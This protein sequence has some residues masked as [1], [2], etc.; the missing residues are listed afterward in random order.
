[1][2][3]ARYIGLYLIKNNFCYVHGLG[4]LELK[5]QPATYDG[6]L[7]LPA[8]YRVDVTTGGSIDDN[9]ANF[10]ATN[11]Q[12]SIS[13]AANALR[14][15]SEQA[16]KDLEAGKDVLLPAVGKFVQENGRVVFITNDNFSY[17]P[18]GMPTIRNN[19]QIEEQV[20][21]QVPIPAAIPIPPPEPKKRVNWTMII[22]VIVLLV[23]LGGG[24]FG[25][26]YYKSSKNK[27]PLPPEKPVDSTIL[28]GSMRVTADSIR[29]ADS[30]RAMA[31]AAADTMPS[32]RKVVIGLYPDLNGADRYV[33][34]LKGKGVS[35]EVYVKDTADYLVLLS[36]TCRNADTLNLFDSLKHV[37]NYPDVKSFK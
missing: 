5:K 27:G 13:K 1:M 4:N 12:V 6:K 30:L 9:L 14:D 36:V 15:F 22:L 37:Y 18:G 2:D 17:K 28:N 31:T 35:A 29:K 16:K 34:Q 19:K 21:K 26:Y 24:G 7:L 8:S 3:I 20:A 25:Y 10:I 23:I 33:R 32:A 11:E